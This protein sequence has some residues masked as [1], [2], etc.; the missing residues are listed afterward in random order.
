MKKLTEEWITRAENDY[1][2]ALRAMKETIIPEAVC[3]H[4]QQCIEKYMKAILQENDI[5]FE[6]VHDIGVLLTQCRGSISGLEDNKADLNQLSTYAVDARY[7]GLPISEDE[8]RE[9]QVIMERIRK[10]IREYF[11]LSG[12]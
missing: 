11:K 4:A 1:E 9:C 10:I 12:N 7:P 3:F 5:R 6:R 8:A 2:M